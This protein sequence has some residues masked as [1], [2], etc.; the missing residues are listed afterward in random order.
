M[1]AN[2]DKIVKELREKGEVIG[3]EKGIVIG[4]EQGNVEGVEKERVQTAKRL[5]T[6]GLGLDIIS[7]A[8]GLSIPDVKVLLS[9]HQIQAAV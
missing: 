5:Y 9:Q 4:R 1:C 3:Q 7:T 6:A 8:T 2:F